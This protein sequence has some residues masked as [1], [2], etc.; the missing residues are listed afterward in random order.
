MSFPTAV[1]ISQVPKMPH[2]KY[3]LPEWLA[4]QNP[5]DW[6]PADQIGNAANGV[7]HLGSRH[8]TSPSI[9]TA[10]K[11]QPELNRDL[12]PHKIIRGLRVVGPLI[13]RLRHFPAVAHGNPD[14][15]LCHGRPKHQ[16]VQL[17]CRY[18]TEQSGNSGGPEN[19][20]KRNTYLVSIQANEHFT[21]YMLR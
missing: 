13:E 15:I 11:Y 12:E 1:G 14:F 5:V 9:A 19:S 2:D 17:S 6:Y 4:C 20:K 3:L 7:Q 10:T 8:A 18:G 16:D 21:A